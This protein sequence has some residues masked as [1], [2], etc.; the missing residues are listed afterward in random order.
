V[1]NF[2]SGDSGMKDKPNSECPCTAIAS[3]K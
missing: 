1:V 3:Q 2:S